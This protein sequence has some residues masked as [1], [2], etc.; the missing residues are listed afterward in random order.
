MNDSISL[1]KKY[2]CN[3]LSESKN[4]A[5]NL[6]T[7]LAP[8]Y[9]LYLNGDLG[10]GKTFLC[11]SIGAFYE[12]ELVNSSS[13]SRVTTSVGNINIIHCDFYRTKPE[14]FFFEFQIEPLL[15]DP[16][17]LLIEWGEVEGWDFGCREYEIEAKH[18]SK[19]VRQY[20]LSMH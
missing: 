9:V 11:Q 14:D 19:N 2:H 16:W 15:I 1:G 10:T 12:T 4:F 8:P 20:T 13:F 5:F 17:V 7:T 6:A 3:S 18:I